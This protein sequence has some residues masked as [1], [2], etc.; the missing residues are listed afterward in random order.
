M[1]TPPW[2]RIVAA[3]YVVVVA[4]LASF[5]FTTESTS[6]IL[7]GGLL[8]L[9]TSIPAVVGF[10]VVYGLLA[11]VPG[12]NPDSSTGSAS[13]GSSGACQGSVT[14][15]AATWFVLATDITGILAL[16]AAAIVNVALVR[17]VIRPR[18]ASST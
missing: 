12:A 10:Y 9:P 15:D 14:G 5:G 13:C 6:A 7:L 3:T 17:L 2:G 18:R 1:R 11:Q 4:S 8:A 16:T